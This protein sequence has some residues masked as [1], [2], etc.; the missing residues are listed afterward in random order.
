MI[1][2]ENQAGER[3]EARSPFSI[4][5]DWTFIPTPVLNKSPGNAPLRMPMEEIGLQ[6][7]GAIGCI[8]SVQLSRLFAWRRPQI[9]RMLAEKK[10]VQHEL[11]KNKNTIPIFTL[12]SRSVQLL[13]LES[14]WT[15][16]DQW[17]VRS[18][19]SKLVFFQFCCA[20]HDK[21]KGFQIL[22]AAAPFIGKVQMGEHLRAVLVLR[23]NE[24]LPFFEQEIR[25][26]TW[27]IIV[28]AE[29]LSEVEPF[30]SVLS[31]AHVL[32]DKDLNEDYRFYRQI[33]SGVWQRRLT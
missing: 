26:T 33:N 25:R 30:N 23:G 21:Q 32:L 10:L 12:G 4:S 7:I 20:L 14:S 5:H 11:R 27:P 16:P 17:D 3:A 28:I 22:S 29:T 9:R 19:L 13:Q 31:S 6:A 18:V 2:V 1:D 8:G 24:D 15:R